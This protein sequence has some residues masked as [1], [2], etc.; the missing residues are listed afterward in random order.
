LRR[1]GE[2]DAEEGGEARRVLLQ[3][4]AAHRQ[5]A[6]RLSADLLH[7]R[8]Q[9]HRRPPHLAAVPRRQRV[10]PLGAEIA[11]GAGEVEIEL[12]RRRH[13]ALLPLGGSL[14]QPGR[15]VDIFRDRSV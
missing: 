7:D 3:I 1:Q 10:D 9:Q 8:A 14:A 15:V 2:G 6:D 13:P 4:R 11:V 12:D 5:A